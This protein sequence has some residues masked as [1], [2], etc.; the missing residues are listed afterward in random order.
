MSENTSHPVGAEGASADFQQAVRSVLLHLYDNAYL[1]THPLTAQWAADSPGDRLT[2]AQDLRRVLLDCIERLRPQ[3]T[4]HGDAARAYAVLTY[5]CVDGL[6]I[7]EIEDKLGLSRRQTYREFT[8]GVEA[9]AGQLWDQFGGRGAQNMAAPAPPDDSPP[10]ASR[11][12]LAEAEL[13]RLSK[14]ARSDAL[15]LSLVVEGVC[16]LLDSRL[17]QLGI[18]LQIADLQPLSPILADR[19]LLRQALLNLL[20][21][22]LD[23]LPVGST[24]ALSAHEEVGAVHLHLGQA[25]APAGALRA[26]PPPARREGVALTV[27]QSLITAQNGRLI[28]DENG[29]AWSAAIVLPTAQTPTIVIVDDNQ[30]LIDLFQRYLAGHRVAVIGA[31]RGEDALA[32][33]RQGS[34][35]LIVLDVMMPH[36]DGWEVLQKLRR[37][38]ASASIPIIVCSVLREHD[39]ALSLGASDTMV[40]PVSQPVLLDV[41]R[42]WLGTLHPLE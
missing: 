12:E 35:Q 42:R 16:R 15:E 27:A 33:I 21:Y 18:R 3:S 8:K 25:D 40:K 5:R 31:N 29:G 26:A 28:L 36:Q 37:E 9:V 2:H 7:E 34:P 30:N 6:T 11:R 38:P 23:I 14:A 10:R 13:E 4:A 17:Q 41:M 19:T 22:A 39:L 20:S 24:L 32:L 1:Q